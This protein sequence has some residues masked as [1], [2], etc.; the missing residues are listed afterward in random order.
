M[1][2][3]IL[4]YDAA[5][6][7]AKITS[8]ES[9]NAQ[10]NAHLETLESLKNQIPSFWEGENTGNFIQAISKA[11]VKVRKASDNVSDLRR[12]YQEIMDEKTRMSTAVN[13]TVENMNKT[14]DQVIDI[15]G[16]ASKFNF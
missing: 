4:K 7:Q 14:I 3:V 12:M 10:L 9:L 13:D 8:F 11:I 5:V 2:E 6:Y 1:A 15:A 16:T